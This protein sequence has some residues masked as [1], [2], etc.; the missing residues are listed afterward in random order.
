MDL[1]QQRRERLLLPGITDP[2]QSGAL[3]PVWDRL[4]GFFAALEYADPAYDVIADCGRL[5]V[6]NPPWPVLHRADAVLLV[7]RATLPDMSAALPTLHALRTQLTEHGAGASSLGLL[8]T[9][10]GD[11]PAR[12][13]AE[14][15]RTP[16]VAHLPE[17]PRSARVLCH[18]GSVRMT[19]PL[20][21][22]AASA[23]HAIAAH[24]RMR[25]ATLGRPVTPPSG[26]S[27][28]G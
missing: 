17:D 10:P 20:L 21:R 19:A 24:L 12:V 11:Q 27:H 16:V 13:V 4:A 22:A 23:H 8:L 25:R 15:L 5:A 6:V 14:Q 9:G 3:R 1:W 26:V 2:A 28:G 18:G 7:L